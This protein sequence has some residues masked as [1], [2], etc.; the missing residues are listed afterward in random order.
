MTDFG[1]RLREFERMGL[2]GKSPFTKRL[3]QSYLAKADH[4]LMVGSVMSE[5]ADNDGAKK[6]LKVPADFSAFDWVAVSAYYAMYHSALAA[7]STIGYKSSNHT[8]TMVALE[9]FFVEKR[10]LESGFVYKLR[11]ARELEEAYIQKLQYA[12][13][14]RETA[15]YGVTEETGKDAAKALLK[16]A[17]S[18]VDRMDVLVDELA[19]LEQG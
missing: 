17:R 12:R 10:L 4:N 18:F 8:A 19:K 15:Q 14:Q 9:V 6:E 5:L 2:C 16:D 13:K 11:H 1:K 3:A 7:L